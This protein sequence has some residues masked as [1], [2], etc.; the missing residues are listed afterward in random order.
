[1]NIYLGFLMYV[2]FSPQFTSSPQFPPAFLPTIP[3][4]ALQFIQHTCDSLRSSCPLAPL[5]SLVTRVADSQIDIQTLPWPEIVKLIGE[6]RKHNPITSLSNNPNLGDMVG[7]DV[8]VNIKKLDAHDVAK[9]VPI[10]PLLHCHSS[11][12]L[13]LPTLSSMGD[14]VNSRLTSTLTPSRI[15][16]QENYLIA[17]FNKDLLDLRFRF[18][19]PHSIAPHIPTRFIAPS[20]ELPTSNSRGEERKYL[21]LGGDTLTKSLEWNL[22]YCLMAY[23]FD[24]SGQVRKEFV[25]EKRRGDLVD[26]LKRRFVFMGCLNLLFSPFIVV[27]LLIYSFFR[28]FEVCPLL[29]FPLTP[30]P[31][32]LSWR[33]SSLL[34]AY[35]VLYCDGQP[36]SLTSR[37]TTKTPHP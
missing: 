9:Y 24:R 14:R 6:I 3:L 21:T 2:F 26:G 5:V 15:L 30:S 33:L 17:L 32:A 29:T 22:R 10:P 36:A 37:N 28:Y 19:L 1:M 4:L 31:P 34:T 13:P 11:C 20:T 16:R 8:D 35:P 27:Y 25:K 7:K 12:P 18:P 23:L